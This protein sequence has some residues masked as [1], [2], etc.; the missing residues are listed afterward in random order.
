M[1]PCCFFFS[2]MKRSEIYA[3]CK[4]GTP[5]V[6]LIAMMSYDIIA[7]ITKK[8]ALSLGHRAMPRVIFLRKIKLF[9]CI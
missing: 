5:Y 8:A 6:N 7:L 2:R 9:R 3:L 1:W 4:C